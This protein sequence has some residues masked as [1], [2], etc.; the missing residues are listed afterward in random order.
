MGRGLGWVLG[1]GTGL[2]PRDWN[3]WSLDCVLQGRVTHADVQAV[4]PSD[5]GFSQMRLNAADRDR[6]LGAL[7][8]AWVHL[9]IGGV[10]REHAAPWG[11]RGDQGDEAALVWRGLETC[12]GKKQGVPKIL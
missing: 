4:S 11:G 8:S 9:V 6:G 2:D 12:H 3:T 5:T 1:G 10:G 7:G